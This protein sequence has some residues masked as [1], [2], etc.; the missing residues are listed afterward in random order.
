[1]SGFLDSSNF[2]FL[3]IF[4]N[5]NGQHFLWK[6][7]EHIGIVDSAIGSGSEGT[8]VIMLYSSCPHPCIDT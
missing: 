4:Y 7:F 3:S 8:A 2:N 1:M 5:D 6:K